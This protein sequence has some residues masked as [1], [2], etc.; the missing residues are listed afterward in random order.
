MGNAFE[1][2]TTT[3]AHQTLHWFSL[4]VDHPETAGRLGNLEASSCDAGSE[5][6]ELVAFSLQFAPNGAFTVVTPYER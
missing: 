5:F 2:T 1:E 3:Q 6:V 4:T